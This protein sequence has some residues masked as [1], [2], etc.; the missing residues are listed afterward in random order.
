MPFSWAAA[1]LHDPNLDGAHR[2]GQ[3]SDSYGR[4]VVRTSTRAWPLGGELDRRTRL[5]L[6]VQIADRVRDLIERERLR[7]GAALPSEAEIRE[8]LRVSRATIRQ[9]LQQ[10]E[11][12]GR[13]ERHQ[14]RGTFVAVPPLERVLPELTS[15]TEHLASK[16]LRSSSRL[17]DYE[18]VKRTRA[19]RRASLRR[20]I[21][22]DEPEPGLFQP[23]APLVRIVRLRLANEIPIGVHTTLL[24][25]EVAERSAFTEQRLRE[26]ERVSLYASLEEAGYGLRLAEEHLQARVTSDAET[27]LLGVPA[28]TAVMT[29][30]R[31]TRD[32]QGLLLEA[33]RAVY[34]GDKY[35]YVITVERATGKGRRNGR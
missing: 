32:E 23:S 29:V 14:G 26:D 1:N 22:P 24:P 25:A 15:F 21:S 20:A 27:R 5:P 28:R 2:G 13:V 12:D 4:M 17:L 6:Y 18:R 11:Q 33:V 30:L 9:A 16:G 35:D 34:L 31:L 19:A 3:T 10:L 8:S 7:P